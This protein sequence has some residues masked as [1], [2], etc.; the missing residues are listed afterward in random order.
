MKKR[1]KQRIENRKER[2]ICQQHV[3]HRETRNNYRNLTIVRWC[4][5]GLTENFQ[6]V[7]RCFLGLV[8]F[9]NYPLQILKI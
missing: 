8:F 9:L 3:V 4:R 7:P 6:L 2:K 5:G 1:S